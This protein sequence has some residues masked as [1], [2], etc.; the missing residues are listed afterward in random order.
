MR[1]LRNLSDFDRDFH[2]YGWRIGSLALS[3]ACAIAF[4][5]SSG[6]SV[7]QYALHKLGDALAQ[8]GTTFASDDDPDLV[9]DAVPFSLKL[10]ESLLA[11]TPRHTGLLL[12]ASSG[13]AQYAYGFVQQ[14]ADEMEQ[15]D[16]AVANALRARAKRLY[17]RSR[18][19]GL[20][21]LELKH[22]GFE[23]ALRENSK[24][25]LR[26]ANA[27]DVPLLYWTAAAWVSTI[28]LSKDN[29]ELIAD[30]PMVEAMIDRAFELNPDFG[31]SA[32]HT[33]LIAYEAAR[34][35]APG[36]PEA[37][38]RKHF[39]EAMALSKGFQAAPLVSLAETISVKNQ[40]VVEFRSLLNRALAVDVNAKPAWRLENLIMQRRAR[41]LLSRVE[42][43]FLVPDETT[44]N[45]K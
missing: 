1:N 38:C 4:I 39:E 27:S 40:N 28:R 3:L 19:Y 13:F 20:R 14:E 18:S 16:L 11:E 29:P 6:C 34:Q 8:S 31:E 41:W 23:K 10:I 26:A 24:T 45:T 30:L 5:G 36:D 44:T 37:R 12:A 7:R 43:L 21:A 15:R 33:F 35:G 2:P 32:L 22:R 42:E 17:L 25:A 9:K